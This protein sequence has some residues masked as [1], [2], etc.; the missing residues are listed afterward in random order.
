MRSCVSLVTALLASGALLFSGAS[1]A[2]DKSRVRD[3]RIVGL[4]S[5]YNLPWLLAAEEGF[6]KKRGINVTYKLLNS[7][8][9][10]IL[11]IS[12]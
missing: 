11:A 9:E 6:F 4:T 7:G 10:L 12:T 3:I 8:S 2:Q 5:Y 1:S